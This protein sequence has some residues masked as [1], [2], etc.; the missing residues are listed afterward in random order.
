MDVGRLTSLG[1]FLGRKLLGLAR[2][3]PAR[4]RESRLQLVVIYEIGIQIT[5]SRDNRLLVYLHL[6]A[7]NL[8]IRNVRYFCYPT[9]WPLLLGLDCN[10]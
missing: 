6:I 9:R 10:V 4:P 3:R 8:D 5:L 7:F 1:K 2:L